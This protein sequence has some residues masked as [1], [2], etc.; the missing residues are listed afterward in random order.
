[1]IIASVILK[2]VTFHGSLD[3]SWIRLG[4][5]FR[6]VSA[7][8]LLAFLAACNPQDTPDNGQ[9][10]EKSLALELDD[11]EA[12]LWRI[13]DE[14]GR[15]FRVRYTPKMVGLEAELLRIRERL[16]RLKEGLERIIEER[17]TLKV[18]DQVQLEVV[19][20]ILELM[21]AELEDLENA[22]EPAYYEMRP[23]YE[24]R[25]IFPGQRRHTAGGHN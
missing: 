19:R 12:E 6:V 9:S 21:E 8:G 17:N 20:E 2:N 7:F 24:A 22:G 13:V 18:E 16:E 5:L 3:L 15:V 1:M 14:L 23:L 4:P 10:R 11:A 25:P